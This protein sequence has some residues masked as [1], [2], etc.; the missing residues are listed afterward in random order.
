MATQPSAAAAGRRT[1]P[2]VRRPGAGV[3]LGPRTVE[4]RNGSD[5][6]YFECGWT[7]RLQ[8]WDGTR[9]EPVG[10]V[11]LAGDQPTV[12]EG[13]PST[14]LDCV[15][16]D[17]IAPGESR[18]FPF[19]LSQA[20]LTAAEAPCRSRR[21]KLP[22][23]IYEFQRHRCADSDLAVGGRFEIIDIASP[24]GPTGPATGPDGQPADPAATPVIVE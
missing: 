16:L 6:P 14:I 19:E 13:D 5:Q 18:T 4:I 11:S 9:W 12:R 20:R 15:A 23:G 7:Y 17:P 22:S 3:L 2:A 8:R 21:L 24:G 10:L 1:D